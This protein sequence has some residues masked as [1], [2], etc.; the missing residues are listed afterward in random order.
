MDQIATGKF[1][2]ELR[3]ERGMTQQALA[4][5][6]SISEKTVSKWETG[7]GM[8]EVGLMLPLCDALQITVNELLSGKRLNGATFRQQAE[9][10]VARLLQARQEAKKK[11]AV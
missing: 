8:P 1:I 7:K 6:L 5:M 9:E 11:L 10:N 4:D 2:R 3:K